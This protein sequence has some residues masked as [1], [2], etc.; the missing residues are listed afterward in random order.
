MN[1]H[2]QIFLFR[3]GW[4]PVHQ[5][6]L[7]VSKSSERITALGIAFLVFIDIG[8]PRAMARHWRCSCT[9]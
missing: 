4:T 5:S 1:Y 8:L 6:T 2:L 3:I 9:L 7:V